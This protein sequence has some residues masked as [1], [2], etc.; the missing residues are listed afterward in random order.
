MRDHVARMRYM[1]N[2]YKVLV[3]N[4]EVNKSFGRHRRVW[5]SELLDVNWIN[6][7]QELVANYE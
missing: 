2:A 6:V 1:R 3:R 5:I 4:R 7:A